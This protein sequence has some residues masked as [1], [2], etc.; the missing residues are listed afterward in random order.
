MR[1]AALDLD[2]EAM[3]LAMTRGLA[4]AELAGEAALLDAL[5]EP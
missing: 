3:T 5:R 4:L 1:L 2:T